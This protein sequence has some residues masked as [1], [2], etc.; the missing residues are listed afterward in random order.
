MRSYWP[1]RCVEGQGQKEGR[2][3]AKREPGFSSVNGRELLK[4]MTPGVT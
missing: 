4:V 3:G 1:V 2:N